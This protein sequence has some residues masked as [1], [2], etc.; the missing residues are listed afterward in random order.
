MEKSKKKREKKSLEIPSICLL[1]QTTVP[2]ADGSEQVFGCDPSGRCFT[3]SKGP[4]LCAGQIQE[5][6]LA[7]P[8]PFE[9][10]VEMGHPGPNERCYLITGGGGGGGVHW[11]G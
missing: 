2:G 1:W 6:Q 7:D 10:P 8:E 3:L 5:P 9:L 4:S 11:R